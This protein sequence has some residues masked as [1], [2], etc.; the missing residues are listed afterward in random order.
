MCDK[1]VSLLISAGT[2]MYTFPTISDNGVVDVFLSQQSQASFLL[3]TDSTERISKSTVQRHLKNNGNSTMR[4]HFNTIC[5][6]KVPNANFGIRA[7]FYNL[8]SML[9]TM[10]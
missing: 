4:S 5:F 2:Y 6:L 1:L 10:E 7:M 9:S 8:L 3:G